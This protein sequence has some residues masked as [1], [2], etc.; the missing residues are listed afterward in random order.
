MNR[1]TL[2]I[3]FLSTAAGWSQDAGAKA[4]LQ[5]RIG[6]IK[7]SIAQNQAQLK[8]YA[9]TETTEIAVKGE[10]KKRTQADC[11]YGPDGKVQKTPIGSAPPPAQKR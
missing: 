1:A 3:Y 7:Q 8:R 2:A 11:K 4:A 10:D 9:W 6:E 5:Q